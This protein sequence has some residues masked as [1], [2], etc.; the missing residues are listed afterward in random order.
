[1]KFSKLQTNDNGSSQDDGQHGSGL[2]K[3]KKNLMMKWKE[4]WHTTIWSGAHA[5][6]DE[7]ILK[8]F[9]SDDEVTVAEEEESRVELWSLSFKEEYLKEYS[10]GNKS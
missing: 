1:M 9:V 7:P 3:T 2:M 4:K 8:E 5:D 10:D 6:D